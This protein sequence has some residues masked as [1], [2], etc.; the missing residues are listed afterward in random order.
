MGPFVMVPLSTM[1][2]AFTHCICFLKVNFSHKTFKQM[3]KSCPYVFGMKFKFLELSH[4][5]QRHRPVAIAVQYRCRIS[6]AT[7]T[8]T[9]TMANKLLIGVRQHQV[10]FGRWKF[11]LKPAYVKSIVSTYVDYLLL[12]LLRPLQRPLRA[13]T[14]H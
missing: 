10:L 1:L 3:R 11:N 2:K 13:F 9:T 4:Y 7:T 12:R 6:L 14:L 5:K 8:S